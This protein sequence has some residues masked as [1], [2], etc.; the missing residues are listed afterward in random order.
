[1]VK[2]VTDA[3][4][5]FMDIQTVG[6]ATVV[7]LAVLP[8]FVMQVGNVPV[9]PILLGAHVISAVLVTTSFLNVWV[10]IICRNFHPILSCLLTYPSSVSL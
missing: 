10:S 1:M 9:W 3:S 4:L 5:A 2:D 6:H 7:K 8:P